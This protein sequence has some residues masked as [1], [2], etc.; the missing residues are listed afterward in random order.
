LAFDENK[1]PL[2]G[3]IIKVHTII[4]VKALEGRGGG[5]IERIVAAKFSF[6]FETSSLEF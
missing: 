3:E 5:L 4:A 2:R 1:G 6:S